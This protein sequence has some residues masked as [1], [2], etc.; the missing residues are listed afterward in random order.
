MSQPKTTFHAGLLHPKHWLAWALLGVVFLITCLPVR[1]RYALFSRIGVMA[2]QRSAKRQNTV[3]TNLKICFPNL[4]DLQAQ[5]LAR[6]YAG[7]SGFAMA[8]MAWIW[9]RS[10]KRIKA[11]TEIIGQ[12]HLAQALKS[13]RPIMFLVPHTLFLEYGAFCVA[14]ETSCAGIFNTFDNPV[15]DWL[16]LRQRK[17]LTQHIIRR[18]SGNTIDRIIA[19][20]KQGVSM[21]HLLDEDLGAKRS[22]FVPLFGTPKATLANIGHI[23]SETQAIVLPCA[24]HYDKKQDKMVVTLGEALDLFSVQHDPV[25]VATR[26]NQAY[27]IM[28]S[29]HPAQYMWNLKL[30]RHR[31]EGDEHSFYKSRDEL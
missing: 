19:L 21:F 25:A 4:S 16:V 12:A 18:Q 5:A 10:L 2:Y 17:K 9:F 3:S 11:R 29:R 13:K 30:F 1:V 24:T 6:S 27:E 20:G 28:I 26:V 14:Q 8:E 7:Y 22:V 31:P 15:V 23:V